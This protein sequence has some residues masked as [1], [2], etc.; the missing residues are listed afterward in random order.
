[1]GHRSLECVVYSAL[2]NM[3]KIETEAIKTTVG[4]KK[5]TSAVAWLRRNSLYVIYVNSVH[6]HY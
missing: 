4:A 2:W 1:M 6:G 5:Q 3:W